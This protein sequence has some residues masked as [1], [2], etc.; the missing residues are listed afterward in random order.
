MQK[1]EEQGWPWRFAEAFE[2]VPDH[3]IPP[4]GFTPCRTTTD[5]EQRFERRDRSYSQI[6]NAG[7]F[8]NVPIYMCGWWSIGGESKNSQKKKY[9]KKDLDHR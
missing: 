9:S 2:F 6:G 4:L 1:I 8:A 7:I 5:T 3:G